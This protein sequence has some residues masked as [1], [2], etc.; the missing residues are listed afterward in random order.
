M[1]LLMA[2]FARDR[3]ASY[4]AYALYQ[5]FLVQVPKAA[6]TCDLAT[7]SIKYINIANRGN[8]YFAKGTL[9]GD[10]V[11]DAASRRLPNFKKSGVGK[12]V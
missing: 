9:R 10:Q 4:T 12:L 7:E 5:N 6:I 1:S 2:Y 8:R 3:C 11:G